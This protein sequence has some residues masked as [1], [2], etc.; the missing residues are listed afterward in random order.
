[1]G[2]PHITGAVT[3]SWLQLFTC[4][5]LFN[6]LHLRCETKWAL[7]VSQDSQPH[8]RRGLWEPEGGRGWPK[9]QWSTW[10][11]LHKAVHSTWL[12]ELQWGYSK[13]IHGDIFWRVKIKSSTHG[14]C[15]QRWWHYVQMIFKVTMH[16]AC[17]DNNL[18]PFL[19]V[20]G[21]N[22]I[23]VQNRALSCKAL[24]ASRQSRS[25]PDHKADGQRSLP[26]GGTL[27][28]GPDVN[29]GLRTPASAQASWHHRTLGQ[30][31]TPGIVELILS[32]GFIYVVTC[33][34]T[35]FLFLDEQ[36]SIVLITP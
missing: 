22:P 35:S 19:V 1:M 21:H 34:R 11:P 3:A 9:S 29:G 23:F 31:V 5:W 26:K 28:N 8:P 16:D 2:F 24:Q 12:T 13:I 25:S 14:C 36:Y 10:G 30:E 20:L 32:L 33:V 7:T 15:W 17:T 18:N 6:S 4:C 27:P